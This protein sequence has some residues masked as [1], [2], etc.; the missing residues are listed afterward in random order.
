MGEAEVKL[1]YCKS[2]PERAR[3]GETASAGVVR[4][5]EL[6]LGARGK[7]NCSKKN[8]LKPCRYSKGSVKE[9]RRT[10]NQNRRKGEQDRT[11]H[12]PQ[13][14][15]LKGKRMRVKGFPHSET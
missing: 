15:T 13:R 6:S 1:R 7:G 12:P 14:L 5:M 9:L 11:D 4:E 8:V 3:E 2:A 10:T